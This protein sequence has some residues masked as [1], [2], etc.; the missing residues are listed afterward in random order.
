[1][2]Q[3][4]ALPRRAGL[5]RRRRV[6]VGRAGGVRGDGPPAVRVGE[7]GRRGAPGAEHP[8]RHRRLLGPP[9]GPVPAGTEQ[10]GGGAAHRSGTGARRGPG[11]IPGPGHRAGP[12]RRDRRGGHRRPAGPRLARCADGRRARVRDPRGRW[13][14]TRGTGP[15]PCRGRPRGPGPP[16]GAHRGRRGPRPELGAPAHG[17]VV[18]GRR[19]ARTRRG[20]ARGGGA[21]RSRAGLPGGAVRGTRRGAV[22]GTRRGA[23][24]GGAVGGALGGARTRDPAGTGDCAADRVQ[25]RGAL[26]GLAR[27]GVR[28]ASS[29][30]RTPPT[31]ARETG[32]AGSGTATSSRRRAGS[33]TASPSRTRAGRAPAPCTG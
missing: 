3:P 8:A 14:R 26:S 13:G 10:A 27:A 25:R 24:G 29:T 12:R 32:P 28:S 22:R 18:R 5:H 7:R 21:P 31:P 9:G 15:G 20:G 30:T 4:G 16:G 2:D 1:M 17:H 23:G 6:R 33:R 11:R 19:G